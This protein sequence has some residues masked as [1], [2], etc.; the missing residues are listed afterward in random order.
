MGAASMSVQWLDDIMYASNE[1]DADCVI[2]CG[3]HSCKQTWSSATYARGE[4]MKRARI[5]TLFLQG[6]SWIKRMT[7]M[8]ALQET[9]DEFVGNVVKQRGTPAR[10]VG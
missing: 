10:A 8:S 4:L 1:L 7:P 2:Y 3:H 5:P 9:I 6:D